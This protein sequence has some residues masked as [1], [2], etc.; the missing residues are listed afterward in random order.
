[1]TFRSSPGIARPGPFSPGVIGGPVTL[2]PVRHPV[3]RRVP[4]RAR[5][6]QGPPGAGNAVAAYLQVTT[7]SLPGGVTGASYTATTLQAAGGSGAGYTWA[8]ITGP[9]PAG[10]TLTSGGLLSGVVTGPPGTYPLTVQVTDSNADTATAPLILT[11]GTPA[12]ATAGGPGGPGT[13]LARLLS[14]P[15]GQYASPG[16]SGVPGS[17]HLALEYLTAGPS[18]YLGSTEIDR[19]PVGSALYLPASLAITGN[20]SAPSVVTAPG[21]G[22]VTETVTFGTAW[23]NPLATDATLMV[24]LDITANTSLVISAGTGPGSSPAAAVLIPSSVSP[25]GM[26]SFTFWLPAAYYLL[27]THTGTG[28]VSVLSAVLTP[29]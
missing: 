21:S 13:A 16:D 23:Q 11:V 9:L 10:L 22:L 27:I 25:T 6:G 20:L 19:G 17:W 15:G 18:G 1:M 29:V 12:V 26:V 28:T 3:P 8:L 14:V 2:L 4:Q 24:T 7:T 5:A